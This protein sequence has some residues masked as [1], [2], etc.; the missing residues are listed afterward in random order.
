MLTILR[1][2]GAIMF[3]LSAVLVLIAVAFVWCCGACDMVREWCIA[4]HN[5][6]AAGRRVRNQGNP[7]R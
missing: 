1:A 2:F 7:E 6:V 3:G 4:R 5:R